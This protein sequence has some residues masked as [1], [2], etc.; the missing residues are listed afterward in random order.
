VGTV[1]AGVENEIVSANLDCADSI[2]VS[3]GDICVV[4]QSKD[5][6]LR[7][8]VQKG[9]EQFR[10][11]GGGSDACLVAAW[12]D[13]S[14]RV[15]GDLIFD[16]EGLWQLYH[17]GGH[18]VF[19]FTSP[20]FGA[21]PYKQ[22]SFSADFTSGEVLLHAEYFDPREP[23]RALEYPLDELLFTNL[24]ARG[25]G[26]ELHGFGVQDS[27]GRGYLFLGH[28]GDGKTTSARL[29]EKDR[30]VQI[31][32]D[33]RIILRFL[34]GKLW[35]YGT[36]WHGEAELAASART[37]L[38]RIFFLGRGVRNYI[39]P[40][41]QADTVGGLFARS[42]VPFYYPEGLDFTLEILQRIAQAV[43]CAE[44]RFVPDEHVVDF[45]RRAAEMNA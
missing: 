31:L 28:S 11:T 34:E 6:S 13:L 35:M 2:T 14:K 10:V 36:P 5:T 44:L 32:S 22:A 15:P 19:R 33:D 30:S 25:R 40:M 7:L 17:Q 24:L 21:F 4:N 45:V 26:V 18:Y 41:R 39:V 3:I 37:E 20:V 29:W 23:A 38:T 12:G 9:L 8:G 1:V 16:S 43:P 42:F 27:D